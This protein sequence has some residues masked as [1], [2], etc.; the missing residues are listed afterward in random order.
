M[1]LQILSLFYD[2]PVSGYNKAATAAYEANI[3]LVMRQVYFSPNNKKSR[4]M[5]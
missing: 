1:V 5:W 3:F 2:K 4:W